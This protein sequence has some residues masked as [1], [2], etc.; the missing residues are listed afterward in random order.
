MA[1]VSIILAT[2]NRAASLGNTL[3]ALSRLKCPPDLRVEFVIVDN[4]STDNTQSVLEAAASQF[5]GR[6]FRT[7]YENVPGKSNALNRA[8]WCSRGEILLFTDDDVE[9]PEDWIERMVEPILSGQ[10]D[11]VAGGVRLANWLSRSWL[12]TEQR[13]W[14]AS[15]EHL[16]RSASHP[17]IGANMALSRKVFALVQHFDPEVG[18]GQIGHAEDTFFWLQLRQAGC[19]LVTRLD[20]EVVHR[21]DPDRLCRKSFEQLAE[22][23]GEFAAYVDHHWNHIHRRHP[24]AALV[25]SWLCLSLTRLL[26]LVTWLNAPTIPVWEMAPL[27]YY[28]M[29]RRLLTERRR[30]RNYS[31]HG[32]VKVNGVK[33]GWVPDVQSSVRLPGNGAAL[34]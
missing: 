5:A 7:L 13:S 10:A 4:G 16:S 23:R 25:Q 32:L 15:T 29:R 27:E 14:L 20:V 3:S 18:P 12:G 30:P 28:H 9:P 2:R 31:K 34:V 8:V 6:H 11:G 21:V 22:K 17:L 1:S 19:K 33:P 24:Y 26:N